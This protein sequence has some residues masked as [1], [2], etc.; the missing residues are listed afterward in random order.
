MLCTEKAML[1]RTTIVLV[2]WNT[3]LVAS[4]SCWGSAGAAFGSE[5]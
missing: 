4:A 2:F 1:E 5:A 3:V